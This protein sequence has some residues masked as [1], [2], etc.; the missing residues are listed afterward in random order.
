MIVFLFFFV[1]FSNKNIFFKN[2]I[3]FIFIIFFLVKI[4]D[5]VVKG[6]IK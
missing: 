1:N 5:K 4:Y 6:F 2:N 3:K